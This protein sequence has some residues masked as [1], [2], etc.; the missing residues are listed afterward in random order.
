MSAKKILWF[1]G[2][3]GA[4]LLTA[5]LLQTAQA[6][7][8]VYR[9]QDRR[10]LTAGQFGTYFGTF[11]SQRCPMAAAKVTEVHVAVCPGGYCYRCK[12]AD[13]GTLAQYLAAK[14]AAE[15]AGYKFSDLGIASGGTAERWS[16]ERR[17]A[18]T[19]AQ[20]GSYFG[21]YAGAQCSVVPAKVKRILVTK[22]N[23]G[24]EAACYGVDTA[25]ESTVHQMRIDDA[26]TDSTGLRTVTVIGLAQ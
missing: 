4:V 11:A 6:G 2:A 15:A 10:T 14:V 19:P 9:V 7:D 1:S 26:A 16:V 3:G 24:Y 22:R 8:V 25:N 17:G 5:V 20:A 12:A 21:A 13:S 18:L 23:G